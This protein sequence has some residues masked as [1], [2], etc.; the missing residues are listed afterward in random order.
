MR[1]TSLTCIL[2]TCATHLKHILGSR[3]ILC[4]LPTTKRVLL[5]TYLLN[6]HNEIILKIHHLNWISSV[7]R[8]FI[9]INFAI[10]QKWYFW[11]LLILFQKLELVLCVFSKN[12]N[13]PPFRQKIPK[14]FCYSIPWVDIQYPLDKIQHIVG[15]AANLNYIGSSACFSGTTKIHSKFFEQMISPKK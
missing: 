3:Y 13:F 5:S 7:S 12:S 14:T 2:L 8:I 11:V 15:F 6:S 1:L 9:Y 10:F 4:I